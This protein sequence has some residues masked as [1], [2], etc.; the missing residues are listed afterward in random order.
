MD[1]VNPQDLEGCK[2][3]IILIMKD[4]KS[5][6]LVDLQMLQNLGI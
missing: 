6:D 2:T 5:H 1:Y 4:V 3:V